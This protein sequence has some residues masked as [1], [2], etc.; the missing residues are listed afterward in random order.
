MTEVEFEA[1]ARVVTVDDFGTAIYFI[2]EGEVEVLTD[3]VTTQA[4]APATRSARS[5]SS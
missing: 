2:Q 1:G 5:R 3:G 4:L